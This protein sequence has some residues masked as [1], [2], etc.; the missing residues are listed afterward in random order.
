MEAEVLIPHSQVPATCPYHETNQ[1]IPC[2]YPNSWRS[3]LILFF[4]LCLGLPSGL[5]HSVLPTKILVDTQS[6]CRKFVA[7]T[8]FSRGFPKS[9]INNKSE[10]NLN[11]YAQTTLFHF[12]D[13]WRFECNFQHTEIH[14]Y[15]LLS[16]VLIIVIHTFLEQFPDVLAI[17]LILHHVWN[18]LLDLAHYIFLLLFWSKAFLNERN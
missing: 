17:V 15:W 11:L 13:F 5:F 7:D 8:G 18:C 1:F 9:K 14:D 10:R 2:P 3:I 16:Y 12:L 6:I 4:Y